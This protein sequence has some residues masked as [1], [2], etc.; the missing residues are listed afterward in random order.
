MEG[1]YSVFFTVLHVLWLHVA[2]SPD[3]W[4]QMKRL[5]SFQ[6]ETYMLI[7]CLVA[8]PVVLSYRSESSSKEGILTNE[9]NKRH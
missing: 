3:L 6:R 1:E 2:H 5:Q 7:I 9:K 4:D 8:Q